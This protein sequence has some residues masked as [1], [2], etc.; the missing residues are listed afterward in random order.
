VTD[1]AREAAKDP[2][3]AQ[4]DAGSLSLGPAAASGLRQPIVA[5][6]LLI[7]LFTAVSGNPLDGFLMLAVAT[8]LIFHAARS[9]LAGAL[10]CVVVG[11]FRRYSWPATAPVVALGCLMI[12]IGWQSP[13]ARRQPMNG[14]P[15]RRAWL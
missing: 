12:S 2:P 13:L 3:V 1:A 15:L 9:W 11:S 8:L 4:A 10:Y 6:L 5:I 7:A 14:E